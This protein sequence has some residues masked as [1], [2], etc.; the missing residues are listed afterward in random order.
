[1]NPD[2][3]KPTPEEIE[4]IL[5]T[6]ASVSKN[7]ETITKEH[8]E[9]LRQ[10]MGQDLLRVVSKKNKVSLQGRYFQL[11]QVVDQTMKL[12]LPHTPCVNG[13]SHCC[14]QAITVSRLE[15]NRIAAFIHQ[16][17]KEPEGQKLATQ[18]EAVKKYGLM[19]PDFSLNSPNLSTPS[20]S[21]SS[22]NWVL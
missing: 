2:G 22:R 6:D 8:T 1:M 3:K 16:E 9:E 12:V 18:E 15:A 7:I 20:S 13:C 14:H 17:P 5:A 11:T 19:R 21:A 4:Q 10:L